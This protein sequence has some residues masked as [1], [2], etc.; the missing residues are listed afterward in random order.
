[1]VRPLRI[2]TA[3]MVMLTAAVRCRPRR[4]WPDRPPIHPAPLT[5][6]THPPSPS[7]PR[8]VIPGW[9][10][11]TIPQPLN[12][13]NFGETR[14]LAEIESTP[15]F[16]AVLREL[17]SALDIGAPL[18]EIFVLG[19]RLVRFTRDVEHPSGLLE[20]APRSN[21]P[22]RS[23]RTVLD[24]AALNRDEHTSYALSGLSFS[25]FPD[26]CLPPAFDRCLL[27][28]SPG[29]SSNLELREFDLEKGAFVANGF[30]VPANRSFTAW[31]NQDTLLI[32][33]S[34]NNSPALPSNFPAVVRLWRR[35]TPLTEAQPIFQAAPTDSLVDCRAFGL[36]AQRRVLLSVVHDYSTVE[37]K[38]VDQSGQLTDLPIPQK[39]KYVGNVAL[40]YP[41]VV[42]QL[43]EPATTAGGATYPAESLL[44]YNIDPN[45]PAQ[46][47]YA[48]VYVPSQDSF[49]TDG[50]TGF[51]GIAH[52][53][54]RIR[55]SI[56]G[57][58]ASH[59][60]PP[61]PRSHGAAN[62][63]PGNSLLPLRESP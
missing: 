2:V 49:V 61:G 37:F 27:A 1:M 46:R 42:V 21:T 12:G 40:S 14:A 28:L 52:S 24:L 34:L 51:T 63:R 36:G 57:L 23:W 18:P 10:A 54:D 33:H 3:A 11:S 58:D 48:Q 25:D 32:A 26:R 15:A 39:V 45:V 47:R 38:L 60:G 53:G 55:Q 29:G 41:Y 43:A 6:S 19:N 62:G 8:T 5:P 13:Q 31:L 56:T 30:R 22:P 16:P 59:C 20:V 44:A 35:G 17:R 4:A 7:P 50:Y 9:K